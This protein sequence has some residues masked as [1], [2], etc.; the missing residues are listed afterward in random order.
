VADAFVKIVPL[1]CGSCSQRMTAQREQVVY[2]CGT[3]GS[4]WELRAG[5]I[6]ARPVVHLSGNGALL[7]PF[8]NARFQITCE[9]GDI[10]DLS[11]FLPLCGSVKQPG[12][13]GAQP[14]MLNI[15]AFALPPHQAVK[16]ARN[17]LVRFPVFSRSRAV[18]KPFEAV[19]L[20]ESDIRPLAELIVLAAI[21]EKRRSNPNFLTSFSVQLFDSQ[22]VT[23]PFDREGN[24][25]NQVDL[26]LEV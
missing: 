16:L 25:Y 23:I 17:M 3:C 12:D 14:L 24:R 6:S 22:L 19:T 15:P 10:I 4:S 20:T 7:L 26:N 9:V 8:W 21:V 1:I 13:K 18:D 5:L 11:G 2:Q